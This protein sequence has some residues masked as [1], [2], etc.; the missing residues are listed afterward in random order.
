MPERFIRRV[1]SLSLVSSSWLAPVGIGHI[2]HP[3]ADGGQDQGQCKA[4]AQD[5]HGQQALAR[6]RF[7]FVVT[8]GSDTKQLLSFYSLALFAGCFLRPLFG[9]FDH[10]DRRRAPPPK[11]RRLTSLQVG[12]NRC[13][14]CWTHRNNCPILTDHPRFV[15]SGGWKSLYFYRSFSCKMYNLF[16]RSFLFSVG[17]LRFSIEMPPGYCNRNLTFIFRFGCNFF[18]FRGSGGKKNF[19]FSRF[20]FLPEGHPV[21]PLPG[22]VQ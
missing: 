8:F 6:H 14:V 7:L 11:G 20:F 15:K 17:I 10:P 9:R 13:I 16:L 12:F 21:R 18:R 1:G 19:T 3:D 4:Q 22:P 5:A 2:S